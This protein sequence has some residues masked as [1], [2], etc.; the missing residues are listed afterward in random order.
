MS[1]R[2]ASSMPRC[3][4]KRSMQTKIAGQVMRLVAPLM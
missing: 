1:T 3:L 2:R 4:Y